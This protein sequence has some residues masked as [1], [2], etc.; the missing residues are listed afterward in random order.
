MLSLLKTLPDVSLY[1]I[2]WGLT[3]YWFKRKKYKFSSLYII[4]GVA[5]L[6][7][8]STSY[9]PKKLIYSIENT[10]AP[11][12]LKQLNEAETYYIHVLGAGASL[13]YRLPS[14]MNLNS[15]TLSR[16]VEGIRIYNHLENGVLVTSA[17]GK[18]GFKSQA[19]ISKETAASLGVH[20]EDVKM[21]E[22]PTTTLEEAIA[23]KEKFG[24]E[25]K[26]ILVTSALHLPRAVEIFKDQ[27]LNVIPAPSGYIYKEGPNIYNGITFPSFKSIEL[28]NVY[29][30]AKL[31]EWYYGLFKD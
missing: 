15:E 27:G 7:V 2:I 26:V 24:T 14:S 22:T 28:M 23:F 30:R 3:A 11:I 5:L 10:Y 18:K 31:K 8:C 20:E 13:D 12:D 17:S 29:H 19:K 9:I 4:I 1:F 21:L 16:L 25:K 6:L